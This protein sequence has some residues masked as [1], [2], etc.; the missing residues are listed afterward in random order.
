MNIRHYI[1][2]RMVDDKINETL[3]KNR[4]D[5]WF[6]NNGIVIACEDFMIDGSKITL[7][8]FSIVNGGQ[9]TYLIGQ[10]KGSTTL[11]DSIYPAKSLQKNLKI[12]SRL[13]FPSRQELLRPQI[14]RSLSLP[15]T[16][17]Q[18]LRKCSGSPECSKITAFI[19]KLNAA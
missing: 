6:L 13:K 17:N 1:R 2:S 3:H 19:L 11:K 14:H 16:L 4:G 15:E 12:K 8:N 5:F 18:I 10:Y 9:T 7:T